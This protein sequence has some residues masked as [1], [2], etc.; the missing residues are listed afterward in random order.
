MPD[1]AKTLMGELINLWKTKYK[2]NP[3]LLLYKL[4]QLYAVIGDDTAYGISWDGNL[5][6]PTKNAVYDKIQTLAGSHDDHL[7]FERWEP[8]NEVTVTVTQLYDSTQRE[9]VLDIVA[10]GAASSVD[11]YCQFA[12][13]A[14]FSAFGNSSDDI[15]IRAIQTAGADIDTLIT[16]DFIDNAG[17]DSDDDSV[18]A[19]G[20]TNV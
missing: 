14:S 13:P 10:G 17:V 6:T 15:T 4:T 5:A 1:G 18:A 2:S 16:I 12:I 11:I 19:E 20:L 9:I 3:S 7:I 8:D